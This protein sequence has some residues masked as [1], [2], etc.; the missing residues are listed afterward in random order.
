MKR[1]LTL[2]GLLS[3]FC[4]PVFAQ[5]AYVPELSE[6]QT[7]VEFRA[8]ASTSEENALALQPFAMAAYSSS[9]YVPPIAE[10]EPSSSLLEPVPV[11]GE[12][13]KKP[14]VHWRNLFADSLRFLAVQHAFR[15]SYEDVTRR[16]LV[17]GPFFRD[18]FDSVD[19]L[20]GWGDRD[21]FLVNYVGHTMQG[22]VAG[23]I[24]VQNDESS[25]DIEFGNNRAYWKSRLKAT[26]FSAIYSVQ[27]E[28]GPISE[29]S[30]GNVGIDRGYMGYVDL[31]VTPVVGL[32]WMVAE[33]AIDKHWLKKSE[34]KRNSRAWTRFARTLFTPARAFAN[35]MHL[36]APWY[37]E[38]RPLPGSGETIAQPAATPVP[39]GTSGSSSSRSGH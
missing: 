8:A 6:L 24:W 36:K 28:L 18:W 26:A 15:L 39:A 22:A 32:G 3:L 31:V 27:F 38:N 16:Y 29:A 33:D 10:A 20:A 30:I 23:Y 14:R 2:V 17:T 13:K 19:G 12:T 1:A 11:V 35:V 21:V 5:H 9:A 37:R 34:A 7:A 4:S 25:K